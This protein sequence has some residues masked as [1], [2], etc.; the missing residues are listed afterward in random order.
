MLSLAAT[1]ALALDPVRFSVAGGDD[2]LTEALADASLVVS[3]R[4]DGRTGAQDV[5]A[6]ANADYAKLLKVLY[7]RGYYGGV[8]DIEVDGQEAGRLSPFAKKA[9]VTD[10]LI[11][12]DPGQP[13][14][15]ATARIAPLA[16]ETE[17]PDGFARGKRARARVVKRAVDA[18]VT[19]WREVG[20]AKAE[21]ADQDLVA[22]HADSTLSAR[23]VLRPGPEVRFGELRQT[24]PSAVRPERLQEIAGLPT[25][26]RFS[27]DDLETSAKRLRRTGAFKSVSLTEAETLRAGDVMD[28][29][30]NVADEKPRRFGFGAEVSSNEGAGVSAF[31]LH[32]NILGGAERLRFDAA[33][34]GIGSQT[35]GTH[36][37]IDYELGGRFERPAT[38]GADTTL[39]VFGK[40]AREDEPNYLSDSAELGF[41]FSRIVTDELTLEAG[42]SLRYSDITDA[43]GSREFFHLL[44]PLKAT[45][46]S[47]DVPLDPSKGY[48]AQ[49]EVTPFISLD[50]KDSGGR[51]Y[52][53][54]RAYR[55]LDD[56]GLFTLAGRLQ[57]GSILGASLSETP[58]DFLFYSG[59]GDTVRGQPYQSLGVPQGG[60][61][62]TGGR[63]FVGASAELRMDLAG[64][65]DPVAFFDVGY[66]GPESLYDGSGR[67]HSGAGLGLRYATGIGPI[68]LDVGLP[69]SGSTD[70]GAQIYI[71]IGQAF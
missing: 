66:V 55:E 68:R 69:V 35:G 14:T 43:L 34:S 28:I 36:G 48:Y 8:I 33:I 18:G 71:G 6:A 26:E 5:I 58:Q 65:F 50:G 46:D 45:Y 29:K 47:R 60:G 40:L 17:L 31:W 41:G 37:G 15:F 16:P 57:F 62:I 19:G 51:V 13:F 53:D 59:G 42:L 20:R 64:N 70:D 25:G 10:V 21:L 44:V 61:E 56:G 9:Q 7:E 24:T 49:A 1:G 67:W 39:F 54:G 4:K 3:A 22:D 12:V 11:R 63:S 30:M 32:R 38:F 23:L 2:A 52:L 27:P